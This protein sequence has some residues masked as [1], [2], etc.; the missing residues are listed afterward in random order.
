M[1]HLYQHMLHLDA[2][3]TE[4][5]LGPFVVWH[6]ASLIDRRITSSM[7]RAAAELYNNTTGATGTLVAPGVTQTVRF[8]A[9]L[10]ICKLFRLYEIHADSI[11][12]DF[13]FGHYTGILI[14]LHY[15]MLKMPKTVLIHEVY[16]NGVAPEQQYI[17]A[18]HSGQCQ[19]VA[20]AGIEMVWSGHIKETGAKQPKRKPTATRRAPATAQLLSGPPLASGTLLPPPLVGN[21][22]A[23][24][25]HNPA[26]TGDHCFAVWS[27]GTPS[28]SSIRYISTTLRKAGFNAK[29]PIVLDMLIKFFLGTLPHRGSSTEAT[30]VLAPSSPHRRRPHTV[31]VPASSLSHSVPPLQVPTRTHGT[32]HRRTPGTTSTPL[33]SLRDRC[34]R[35][36]SVA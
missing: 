30:D 6:G 29:D 21:M 15:A 18:V 14:D 32:L 1:A 25:F 17:T 11:H 16:R 8:S 27:K 5:L 19:L 24:L 33:V 2:L 4:L 12:D 20:E 31:V 10:R 36:Q 7:L 23:P 3:E 13:M 9:V 35:K 22:P 28:V 34:L 26:H